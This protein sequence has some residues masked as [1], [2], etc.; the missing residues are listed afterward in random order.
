MVHFGE[1][2]KTWSLRSNS[3]TRQDSFNKSKISGKCQ[4]WKIQM[5]HFGW[6]SDTVH[7]SAYRN[8]IHKKGLPMDDIGEKI[9][10]LQSVINVDFFV[11]DS[12]CARF[13]TAFLK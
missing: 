10:V 3:V 7:L 12:Q 9:I 8:M 2:L 13:D 1:F 5:R 4:N 6:F 11:V